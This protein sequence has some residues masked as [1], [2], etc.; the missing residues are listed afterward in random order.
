LSIYSVYRFFLTPL[1]LAYLTSNNRN[2][3]N[4]VVAVELDTIYTSEFNDIN[5]KHVGIDINGLRSVKSTSAGYFS[6]LDFTNL[7][8]ISDHPMQVRVEYDGKK[9]QLG[10]TLAPTNVIKHNK[11]EIEHLG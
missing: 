6:N 8:L 2:Q 3:T 9:K 10:V 11:L 5:D 4:H 1:G 7:T